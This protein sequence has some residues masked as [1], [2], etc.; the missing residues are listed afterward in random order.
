[1][2]EIFTITQHKLNNIKLEMINVTL[3]TSTWKIHGL[4][5][6]IQKAAMVKTQL[7]LES[8]AKKKYFNFLT[9]YKSK[10]YSLRVNG[11]YN[12]TI[13]KCHFI[14]NV[15]LEST[16]IKVYNSMS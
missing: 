3:N 10:F 9:I 13:S 15:T 2:I 8:F 12:I 7:V 5:V 14:D 4:N 1:M 6:L 16:I 11:G